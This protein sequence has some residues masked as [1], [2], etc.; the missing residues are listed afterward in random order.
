MSAGDGGRQ[1][2]VKPPRSP[3]KTGSTFFFTS[4]S[5]LL[6]ND[7]EATSSGISVAR[8]ER[9]GTISHSEECF[10]HLLHQILELVDGDLEAS[11]HLDLAAQA[12]DPA[13]IAAAEFASVRENRAEPSEHRLAA[14]RS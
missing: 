10:A 1:R 13:K 11:T 9:V 8:V 5:D 2:T 14:S 4:A 3:L 12:I 6:L 7:C